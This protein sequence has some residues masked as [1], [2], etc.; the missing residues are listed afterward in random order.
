MVLYFYIFAFLFSNLVHGQSSK[1]KLEK[2]LELTEKEG[3]ILYLTSDTFKQYVLEG[4]KLYTIVVLFT[5]V[6]LKYHC[7][8]CMIIAPI[9]DRIA[10][11]YHRTPEE[12][13]EKKQKPVFFAVLDYMKET[14]EIYQRMGFTNLPNFLVSSKSIVQE[15]YKYV[16]PKEKLWELAPGDWPNEE[17]VLKFINNLTGRE[18]VVINSP[19][20]ILF[21]Y[22]CGTIA[23]MLIGLVGFTV[24]RNLY[25]P[26]LWWALWMIVYV[27]CIGGVVYDIL[28]GA[29]IVGIAQ[30]TGVTE[31]IASG[32]RSQYIVEGFLMSSLISLGGC[33]LICINIS[34]KYERSWLTRLVGFCSILALVFS[35]YQ[36]TK[37]YKEKVAWYSPT[38]APPENYRKGP[39][40]VD[41]GNSF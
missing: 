36:C 40:I 20:E 19:Y 12:S 31:Y 37:V 38:F 11:S 13:T 39:L 30:K 24:L 14:S 28:H 16:V 21:P 4:S 7:N 3:D 1:E 33:A 23:A 2:L 22:M 5:A 17:K 15:G 9:Y 35:V 10:Y 18:V 8:D 26:M 25:N 29:Q 6:E 41:Q 27:V 32:P 34:A